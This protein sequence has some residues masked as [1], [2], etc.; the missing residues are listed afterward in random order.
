MEPPAP[1][2][3]FANRGHG[4]VDLQL[5]TPQEFPVSGAKTFLSFSTNLQ[6]TIV[7][8]GE[9][10]TIDLLRNGVVLATITYATAGVPT[11]SQT[12]AI[13]GGAYAFP[14]NY[15]IRLTNESSLALDLSGTIEVA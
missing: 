3:Y 7:G 6:Q 14:D 9:S 13:V 5:T 8:V 4:I 2:V 1:E 11:G 15:D 12:V 10:V